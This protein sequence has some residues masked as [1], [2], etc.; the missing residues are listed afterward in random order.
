MQYSLGTTVNAA[1]QNGGLQT[2]L[3]CMLV[4][5]IGKHAVEE[6][7]EELQRFQQRLDSE[8]D[9]L[10]NVKDQAEVKGIVQGVIELMARQNEAVKS[11]YKLYTS[12]LGKALRLM[13]ETIGDV[14][15]TSQAGVHQLSVI[16]K[17]LEEVT[18]AQ[19]ATRFRSKLAVCLKMILEH[20]ETMRTQSEE[21]VKHLKSFVSSTPAGLQAAANFEDPIDK[22][23]GL[24][25]R[26]FA[27]NLINDRLSRKSEC[28]VGVVALNRFKGLS[29]NF[30]PAVTDDL[31][32]TVARQLT[33]RLPEATE[34]CRWSAN[35]FIA[36]TDIVSSYAETS[37][38]WSRVRG[39]KIEKQI[40]DPTRTAL[41]SLNTNLM[42]EHLRPNSSSRVF[43][44]E[45][46]RFVDQN[47]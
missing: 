25:T 20:S 6:K 8:I 42:L 15:K 7:Q 5:N 18:V 2:D 47:T 31:V 12:E 14:S 28:M 38:Q 13:V 40:E 4:E 29:E 27:E 1:Q 34:L 23:T 37:Q 41:V 44:H 46:D 35:S 10:R 22:V 30:G 36:I 45:V 16:Q 19:D 24:P 17:N 43:V 39:L 3:L 9:R 11:D 21:R 26:A 33:Q 32:K